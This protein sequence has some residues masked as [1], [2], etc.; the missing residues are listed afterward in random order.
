MFPIIIIGLTMV[1]IYSLII[2]GK[3]ADE[4]LHKCHKEYFSKKKGHDQDE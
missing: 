2:T 4:Q 3:D 1:V